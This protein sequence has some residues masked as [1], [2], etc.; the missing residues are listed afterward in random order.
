MKEG[1]EVGNHLPNA[2]CDLLG[3]VA[4]PEGYHNWLQPVMERSG[5]PGEIDIPTCG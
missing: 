1:L 2:L 4:R 3:A 5:S